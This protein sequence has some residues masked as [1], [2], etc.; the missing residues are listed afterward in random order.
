[1]LEEGSEEDSGIL[2][3]WEVPRDSLWDAG[4]TGEPR[5]GLWDT[6]N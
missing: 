6:G 3:E 5:K 4:G 2:G 1:M